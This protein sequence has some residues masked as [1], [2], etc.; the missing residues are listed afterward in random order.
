MVE[1]TEEA[2]DLGMRLQE[3]L[4]VSI[5]VE[6]GTIS[7]VAGLI[8]ALVMLAAGHMEEGITTG[9]EIGTEITM[10]KSKWTFIHFES[11]FLRIMGEFK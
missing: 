9:I 5:A 3:E 1:T 2:T 4:P 6:R 11:F 10:I 7:P 8:T